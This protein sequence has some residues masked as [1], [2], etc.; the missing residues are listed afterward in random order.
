M[1]PIPRMESAAS[2]TS[3]SPPRGPVSGAQGRVGVVE[4]GLHA[5]GAGLLVAE[6]PAEAKPLPPSLGAAGPQ[7]AQQP[8]GNDAVGRSGATITL[9]R[10]QEPPPQW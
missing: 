8:P 5:L 3:T 4:V 6:Q 7:L 9:R 2:T 1:P 10:R